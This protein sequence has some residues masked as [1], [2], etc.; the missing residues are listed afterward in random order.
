MTAT[1]NTRFSATQVLRFGGVAILAAVLANVL[2][3]LLLGALIPLS[4]EFMP[5]ALGSIVLFTLAFTLVGVGVLALV[6]RLSS[7]PLRLYNWIG[8]VAFFLSLLPNLAGAA[9]PAALPMGGAGRD[10]LVLIIFH[11]VAA[12]AFLATLNFLARRA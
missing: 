8:V 10:Y 1:Q 4:S 5:F 2:A 6:N 11:V 7:Q 3:R 12:A 9:N